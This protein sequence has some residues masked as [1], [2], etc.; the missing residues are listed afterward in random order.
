M[1]GAFVV[2]DLLSNYLEL[3]FVLAPH[4]FLQ[5]ALNNRLKVAKTLK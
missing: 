3:T 4:V 2:G 5:T 1:S